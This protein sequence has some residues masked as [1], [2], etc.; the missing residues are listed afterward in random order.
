MDIIDL[1]VVEGRYNMGGIEQYSWYGLRSQIATMPACAQTDPTG[2]G[3]VAELAKVTGDIVMDN[4][5]DFQKI[6]GTLETAMVKD[7]QVGERDGK[8][9]RTE[10]ELLFSDIT[11]EMLGSLSLLNNSRTV[12]L[13]KDQNSRTRILGH[14][15]AVQLEGV[16]VNTGQK[17]ADRRG[18]TIKG[19]CQ[20][21]TPA[22]IFEGRVKL[23]GS[24]SGTGD[25]SFQDI[26]F[27]D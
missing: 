16:E 11:P 19:Y 15:V 7:T 18:V 8:S 22:P 12:W 23:T 9:W 6:Y 17:F 4:G 24:T 14:Q 26:I 3:N 13:V 2:S 5:K 27:V 10:F 25:D 21:N 1:D 20:G